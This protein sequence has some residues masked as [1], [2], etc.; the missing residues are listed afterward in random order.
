MDTLR[1]LFTLHGRVQR[2]QYLAA[3]IGLAMV[4]YTVD[5][6]T[7]LV[8]T[9]EFWDPLTYLNPRFVQRLGATDHFPVGFLIFLFLWALPFLWVGVGMSSRRAR[10][11]GLSPWLGLWFLVPYFSYVTILALVLLPSRK[12]LRPKT[13]MD[14][15]SFRFALGSILLTIVC[16]VGLIV[17]LTEGH[18]YYGT[19]LFFGVPFLLGSVTAYLYNLP[20]ERSAASTLGTVSLT[21]LV[22]FLGLMGFGFEGYFCLVIAYPITWTAAMGGALFGRA[23]A[24]MSVAP[25]MTMGA[26][27]LLIPGSA[28]VDQRVA[29]PGQR[30]V[31]TSIDIDAPPAAVWQN[32][33]A[34]SELPQPEHWLFNTGIAYPLRARI[35]VTGVGA[36]RHCEFSTGSFVEPITTWDEPRTLSFDV[37]EQPLPMEEWSFYSRISPPHLEKSFRSV[38]GEFRLIPLPDGGTRLEGSTWYVMDL[39]P[40]VYWKV[41]GDA[42]LHRIHQRVLAHVKRLSEN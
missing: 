12:L 5:C 1:T 15:F 9:G 20:A 35:E 38:R 37:I 14:K 36:V 31:V 3:G 21:L 8:V 30:E 26:L 11:A 28:Y 27:L 4:K 6:V 17:L 24:R 42:I 18:Q 16:A 29:D 23:L 13:P 25:D 41:W 33:V 39:G 2:G 7:C 19:A 10:D 34:F 22:G 32:V 40:A